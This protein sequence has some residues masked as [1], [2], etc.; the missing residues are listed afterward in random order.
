ML[1]EKY[2]KGLRSE[3]DTKID[4]SRVNKDKPI[5]VLDMDETLLH[6]VQSSN[7]NFD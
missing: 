2:E 5:V 7:P 1:K 3:P 4:L 6:A